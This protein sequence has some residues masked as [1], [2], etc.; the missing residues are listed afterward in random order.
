LIEHGTL[1]QSTADAVF[2][3]FD[4]EAANWA[5]MLQKTSEFL[6]PLS[7]FSAATHEWTAIAQQALVPWE[8]EGQL[9]MLCQF[10]SINTGAAIQTTLDIA[11]GLVKGSSSSSSSSGW[12]WRKC[13][14]ETTD[15]RYPGTR[16][17]TYLE[18]ADFNSDKTDVVYGFDE[19]KAQQEFRLSNPANK[20]AKAAAKGAA[21]ALEAA[22]KKAE[23]VAK[24]AQ[25]VADKAK[26][27]EKKEAKKE[28]KKKAKEAKKEAKEAKKEAKKKAKEEGGEE[29]GEGGEE[30]GEEEVEG[31]GE[32]GGGGDE[33]EG[34]GEE[35]EGERGIEPSSTSAHA[36]EHGGYT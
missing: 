11:E 22:V 6:A 9:K 14:E 5:E 16:N 25:T 8:T 2:F 32:E 19:Q 23:K 3:V 33:E 17:I 21:K 35:G 24:R 27:A 15:C 29:G 12:E 34:E 7:V 26:A 13:F 31:G 18:A 30:G 20:A 1:R 10:C 4:V 28:A 36:K